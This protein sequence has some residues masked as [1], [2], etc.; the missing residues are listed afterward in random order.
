MWISTSRRIQTLTRF[1]RSFARAFEGGIEVA[2]CFV[3]LALVIA[4][5][6][7]LV[8]R[9]ASRAERDAAAPSP[10]PVARRES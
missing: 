2:T 9:R 3:L 1:L 10:Q 4:L 6:D 5:A 7:V 8:D